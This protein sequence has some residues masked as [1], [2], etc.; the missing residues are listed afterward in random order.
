[1]VSALIV[2]A[3]SS[4]RM[5]GAADKLLLEVAGC[6]VIAHTWRRFDASPVIDEIVLVIREEAR[7]RYAALAA[8]YAFAKPHRLVAGGPERQD[9]VWNGLEALPAE[10][11]VVAIHDGARPCTAPEIIA[12]T[13]A[14]ARE[15]GAAVAASR[16]TD[17]IKQ[18]ADG[19]W[20]SGT[21]ERAH[22]RAVQTP[23]C[24]R[25]AVIR[26]AIGEARRRG[27]SLTD[28]TAACEL[29]GQRVRLVVSDLP[30]PKVTTP[31]DIPFIES[32]LRRAL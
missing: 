16:V 29:I 3:G 4:R 22:L 15:W 2:A 9:S 20:T 27:V 10:T 11:E 17:T 7:E 28:D 23:Q 24:F 26:A 32:L 30:N 19:D 6:P 12:A 18:T 25:P 13:V 1:M 21:L 14:A 5:G 8:R 31:E